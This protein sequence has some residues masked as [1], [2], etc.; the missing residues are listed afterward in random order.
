MREL[1]KRASLLTCL[2]LATRLPFTEA[3]DL[4]FARY[5]IETLEGIFAGVKFDFFSVA[6][7]HVDKNHQPL[8]FDCVLLNIDSSI[9]QNYSAVAAFD[10]LSPIVSLNPG[11]AIQ[12]SD[13]Y[14]R[15]RWQKS[16]LYT[17]HCRIYDI[18]KILRVAFRFPAMDRKVISFDY[19]GSI[20]NGTWQALDLPQFE[21]ATFPFALAWMYRKGTI[22]DARLAYCFGK[23]SDLSPT[24]LTHLR[25]YVN[26][27]W[28]DLATQARELG[29]SPGGYKQTLYSLRDLIVD[30]LSLPNESFFEAKSR[31]LRILDH[32]FD[33][34]KMLGD[35]SQALVLKAGYFPDE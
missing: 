4:D 21:L 6:T 16:P 33:F 19:L 9:V 27:P 15:D 18:H 29:Y 24:H 8:G 31:S 10:E 20:E 35:P 11:R 22:D 5:Q 34:L 32:D 3:G 17:D 26:S 25:K 28:Q 30:R 13:I 7:T 23:L 2:R 1:Y 12:N 14:D